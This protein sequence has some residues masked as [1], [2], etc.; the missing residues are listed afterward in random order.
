MS[1]SSTQ[2]AM[3]FEGPRLRGVREHFE[4]AQFL[5][6]L[7]RVQREGK[8]SYRLMLAAVY[9]CRGMIELMLEAAEKQEANGLSRDALE[10]RI[11]PMV[12]YYA[13]IERIRIHDFHR[14]GIAP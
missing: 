10:D 3:L 5:L 2:Q 4:R 6:G 1:A 11:S 8:A 14:F 13:L 7:A 9:S 12:P